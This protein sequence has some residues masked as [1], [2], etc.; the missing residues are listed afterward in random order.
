MAV[1]T[2]AKFGQ[3]SRLIVESSSK[4]KSC[5]LKMKE[6]DF[7]Y[8]RSKVNVHM[9]LL[10]GSSST[11]QLLLLLQQQLLQMRQ[12]L[13]SP[14]RDRTLR[15]GLTLQLNS[16][17]SLTKAMWK[18]SSSVLRRWQ[19]WIIFHEKNIQPSFRLTSRARPLRCSLSCQQQIVRI[20]ISLK[21]HYCQH[22]KSYLRCTD[23]VFEAW[24]SCQLTLILNL[25]LN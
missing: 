5:D 24:L 23:A 6:K 7:A 20:T 18:L 14:L 25:P 2:R 15:F 17:R 1:G 3:I 9:S 16:Y 21:Q 12:D 10:W 4:L 8:K 11:I 22:T 13:R 19:N